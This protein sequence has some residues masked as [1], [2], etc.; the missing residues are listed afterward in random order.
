MELY[1]INADGVIGYTTYEP[2][3]GL[4]FK[5]TIPYF[6]E[7]LTKIRNSSGFFPDRVVQETCDRQT[8]KVCLHAHP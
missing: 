5:A 7:Y 2:E 1:I 8:K 3:K 4:D 6:Y